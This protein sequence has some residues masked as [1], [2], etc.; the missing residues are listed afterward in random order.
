MASI[1]TSDPA[2]SF[3]T[4]LRYLEAFSM[5]PASEYA[6]TNTVLMATLPLTLEGIRD[7]L[8]NTTR[9]KTRKSKTGID[10]AALSRALK[11]AWGSEILLCIT[12]VLSDDEEYRKL[13]NNWAAVQAYYACFHIAQALIIAQRNPPPRTHAKLQ[14][15]SQRFWEPPMDYSPLCLGWKN[16]QCNGLPPTAMTYTVKPWLPGSVVSFDSCWSYAAL[17]LRTTREEILQERKKALRDRLQQIRQ[18]ARDTK[19]DAATAAGRKLKHVTMARPR[20]TPAQEASIDNKMRSTALLDVLYRLRKRSNYEDPTMFIDGPENPQQ[21]G[22]VHQC[23]RRIVA[24]TLM[25]HEVFIRRYTGPTLFD[26]EVATW[27]KSS[28]SIS[29]AGLAT[30]QGLLAGC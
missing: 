30:R 23:L 16:G 19:E 14:S 4:Y 7:H 13:A 2:G 27:V 12:P 6:G 9:Y 24:T 15:I 28:G 5:I 1:T 22:Q 20:L 21:T 18:R 25:A 29:R 10:Q 11:N 17:V 26:N 3:R 8:V